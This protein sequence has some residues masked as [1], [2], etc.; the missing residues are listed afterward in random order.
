[1]VQQVLDFDSVEKGEYIVKPSFDDQLQN[2]KDKMNDVEES[3]QK[4]VRK[5]E[6]DLEIENIKFE[7]V[8]HIGYHFRITSRDDSIIRRNNKY[9]IIDAVH[10]GVRF[11]TDKLSDLN[12]EFQ[13]MRTNY[14]EVQQNIVDEVI[15]TA[16]KFYMCYF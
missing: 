8:S 5:A 10:S 7:H 2:I 15:S 1:M 4:L 3:I 11:T 13:E 14:E 9:K 16:C 6:K 12:E